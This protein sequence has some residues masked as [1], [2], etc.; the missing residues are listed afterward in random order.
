MKKSLL[1]FFVSTS[2]LAQ[3]HFTFP[4]QNSNMTIE[5]RVSDLTSRLTLQEKISQMVYN[6]PAIERLGIPA[7]NWW[8]ECLHG[9]ARNGRATVFPQAIGIAATWNKELIFQIGSVISDEARA[10]YNNAVSKNQRG[11]YQGLTFWSPNINIFRDPRWGRGQETYGEDPYLTGQI[12]VQFIRGLQGD[13]PK[14]LKLVATSKHFAVHSG[15]ESDRHSFNAEVSEYDLH[16]TYLPAFKTTITEANVQSIMCAYN[17]L[18]GNACCS[19]EPLLNRILRDE[20]KFNGYVVSDCWAIKDIWE[21]HK[22]AEDAV[23]ASAL[24]VKAGTDLNCGVSFP[25]LF[26]AYQKKMITENE[27]NNSFKRLFIARMKLGMF[28]PP[29]IVPFS[30]IDLDKVDSKEHRQIAL[31][32]AR[33]S[34]VLLKNENSLLPLKKN[35]KNIAVIGPN[36]DDVEVLLGNYTGFPSDPVTPL[37]GIKKKVLPSTKIYYEPGCDLVEEIPN[38]SLIPAGCFFVDAE[39]KQNGL[40]TEIFNNSLF[41]GNPVFKKID[42]NIDYW[43]LDEIPFKNIEQN[44][45]SI[46]WQGYLVPP[47]TGEYKIGGWGFNGLHIY[48]EDF[49]IVSY[50]GEHHPI[51]KFSIQKLEKGKAYKIKIDYYSSSRYSMV[52][53]FWSIPDD[54]KEERALEV[55]KKSDVVIMFMG[56]S[57][58]LEG[59]ELEIEVPGFYKGDRTTLDLPQTQK[60]L[61]TK[62]T[63]IGKP[64]VLVL[65][66][67]S[68]LSIN[69]EKENIPVIVEAWYGGQAAGDAIADVLFGD[70]NP[71]GKLPVTFY[72]SIDQLPDFKNYNMEGRTYRYF[73]GEVLFPFGYGLSYTSFKYSNLRLEKNNIKENQ[74]TRL[75]VDVVNTGKRDGGEV[76]QFYIKGKGLKENDANLTLKGFEK[77][78]LKMNEKRTVEFKIDSETLQKFVDGKGFIVEKGNHVLLVGSSSKK[79]DLSEIV[80]KVE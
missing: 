75:F 68:A 50:D 67:G 19:N 73:D 45:F 26:E 71:S 51:K 64:I 12:A 43:W 11:I 55:A 16:E 62:I 3:T 1:I 49:L 25:S 10:K 5:E 38:S 47:K 17:S 40:L 70:F 59:E 53:L 6:A 32:T 37:R 74:S 76:V 46:R 79:S 27:I 48:F 13:D 4:F 61:I 2:L 63:A 66:N 72:K 57:P 80:L 23:E 20:W 58:R 18:R 33:E 34:I 9:V 42:D 24:A 54:E 69:W 22:Q 52:Q 28:D 36:A 65:L 29:E 14:Y 44:N 15:P 77:I 8:N 56:I 78:F 21:F 39:K 30:K 31:R 35:I 41:E 7:Y 60:S